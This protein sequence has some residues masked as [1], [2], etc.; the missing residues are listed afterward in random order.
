MLTSGGGK[1][2]TH[3]KRSRQYLTSMPVHLIIAAAVLGLFFSAVQVWGLRPRIDTS[4]VNRP[5]WMNGSI[6]AFAP[7]PC[8]HPIF[9]LTSRDHQWPIEIVV[10]LASEGDCRPMLGWG[11]GCY[12][13][14]ARTVVNA[15]SWSTGGNENE[16]ERYTILAR[17]KQC[18]G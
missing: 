6:D 11:V 8:L 13:A 16:R 3:F 15:R 14:T 17:L 9:L 10:I 5:W 18:K 7:R 1:K 2:G 4:I 12:I